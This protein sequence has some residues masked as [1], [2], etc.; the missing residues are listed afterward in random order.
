MR[1]LKDKTGGSTS[2]SHTGWSGGR[3]Y[4]RRGERIKDKRFE[5]VTGEFVNTLRKTQILL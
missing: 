4:L 5:S 2:H 3:G 1:D